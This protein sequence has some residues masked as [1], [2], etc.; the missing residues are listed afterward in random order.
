LE[1]FKRAL[2]LTHS[3]LVFLEVLWQLI[4]LKL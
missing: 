2:I 4:F 1:P 3:S